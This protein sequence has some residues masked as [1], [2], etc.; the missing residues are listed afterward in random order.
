MRWRR[1]I[2]R[3]WLV[4]SVA[5][6]ASIVLVFSYGEPAPL[7]ELLTAIVPPRSGLVCGLGDRLGCER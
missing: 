6:I 5:W 2:A 7:Q 3:T 1:A 4:L